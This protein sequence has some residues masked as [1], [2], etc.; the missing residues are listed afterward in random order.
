MVIQKD[1][2][3]K[4]KDLAAILQDVYARAQ[5]L[6]QRALTG[7]SAEW[8]TM[9][10]YPLHLQEAYTS[11]L[12]S[13]I[14]HPEKTVELQ[15]EYWE[16][17]TKLWQTTMA[18]FQGANDINPLVPPK[19][20][21]RFKSPEW[22]DN[23]M[24]DFIRQSYLL[25][26]DWMVKTID[27]AEDIDEHTRA[28]LDYATRQYLDAMAPSNFV[29]TN[30]DIIAETVRTGGENLM[31]GLENLVEDLERGGG[32][33]R[34]A[35]TDESAFIVGKNIA[36]TKGSVIYRND[37]MELI[38]YEATT[39]KAF[40]TPLLIVP[41]WIN[42]Y[43]ILDLRPDNSMVKWLTEQG[44][45][46]F[47]ISWVNPDETLRD[48]GFDRYVENGIL[49]ALEQ[50]EQAT[51]E[52]D[53]NTI[54]YCIG[55]TLLAITLAHLAAKGTSEKI[56]SATFLTTLLDFE[57]A[58]ELKLF[59]DESQIDFLEDRM[60][61][62][63]YLDAL[64]L[65]RTFSSLRANDLI[66]SFVVNN[67]LMGKE[68]SAFDLLY[69]NNDSTNLPMR[70]GCDYLRWMYLNNDLIKPDKLTICGTKIDLGKIKTPAYFLSTHDDHIAPWRATFAGPSLLGGKSV[71]TLAKSGHI[72]G[73]VN[74]PAV[75]KYGYY[76]SDRT[77]GTASEWMKNTKD[78]DGSWWPH[79]QA[80]AEQFSGAKV[81][82]RIIKK[83]LAAAPGDYVRKKL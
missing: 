22:S 11:L 55:G 15:R 78:N 56:K 4:D 9:M 80:W 44:H 67:Y 65:Q 30:P 62:R 71:F 40:K 82:A 38:Q 68:P 73:V 49:E 83:P 66:W 76:T 8:Q 20:D 35:T 23:L 16:N 7:Q 51:G 26:R 72:A 28:K 21:K 58:G 48:A 45:T 46:V 60:K 34:I 3:S 19:T 75:N 42:K 50:I 57:H 1:S 64:Y 59:I 24:Y 27:S 54:G 77:G 79:W 29:L 41:P 5:P 43:Y 74:P 17:C 2:A 31:R 39:E 25:T 32:T 63:G 10:S 33:L 18:R 53:A 70:M 69:W 6:M 12:T 81:P 13:L 47:M 61:E 36:T 14:S 37:M 52:K